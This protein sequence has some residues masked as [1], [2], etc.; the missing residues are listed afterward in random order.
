MTSSGLAFFFALVAVCSIG[1][2]VLCFGRASHPHALKRT[3][4]G[5]VSFTGVVLAPW[6]VA[7]A[8]MSFGSTKD[9]IEKA[10]LSRLVPLS[11]FSLG[12]GHQLTPVPTTRATAQRS[13]R[14]VFRAIPCSNG[15]PFRSVLSSSG[16]A[17]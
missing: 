11:S 10:W 2:F 15:S 16:D 6:C 5:T 7:G 1:L 4:F 8:M 17:R 12:Y 3:W 13:I 14:T 9:L